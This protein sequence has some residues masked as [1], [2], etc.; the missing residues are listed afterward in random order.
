MPQTELW[1]QDRLPDSLLEDRLANSILGAKV[2]HTFVHEDETGK[3]VA[4]ALDNGVT[5]YFTECW[6][7]FNE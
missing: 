4:V 7:T 6:L 2:D 1:T 3:Y 5:I